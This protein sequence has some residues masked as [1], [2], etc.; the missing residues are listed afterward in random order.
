M[1]RKYMMQ[2]SPADLPATTAEWDTVRAAVKPPAPSEIIER[3]HRALITE[4]NGDYLALYKGRVDKECVHGK[5]A[6]DQTKLAEMLAD[7]VKAMGF[8]PLG[9]LNIYYTGFN[10]MIGK[11]YPQMS[12]ARRRMESRI[13]IENAEAAE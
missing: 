1:A 10:R 12:R 6:I 4:K 11:R 7:K 13:L 3:A 2:G 5:I 8:E 9:K